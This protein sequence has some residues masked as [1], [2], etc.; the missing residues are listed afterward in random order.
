MPFLAGNK[1][2]DWKRM[3]DHVGA[4]VLVV[5]VRLGRHRSRFRPCKLMFGLAIGI[6]LVLLVRAEKKHSF[7]R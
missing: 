3:I 6:T 2:L 1:Y 4:V 5:P 7:D